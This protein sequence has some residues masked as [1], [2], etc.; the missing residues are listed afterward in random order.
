V[1]DSVRFFK[2]PHL[3]KRVRLLVCDSGRSDDEATGDGF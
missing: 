1:R 2:D 3:R